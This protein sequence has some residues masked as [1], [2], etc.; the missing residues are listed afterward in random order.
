MGLV[1]VSL[2]IYNCQQLRKNLSFK[3]ILCSHNV[4][5]GPRDYLPKDN[6]QGATRILPWV[7]HVSRVK[8]ESRRIKQSIPYENVVAFNIYKLGIISRTVWNVHISTK[9]GFTV[10][11][12]CRDFKKHPTKIQKYSYMNIWS[13]IRSPKTYSTR[14]LKSIN[15]RKHNSKRLGNALQITQARHH[16]WLSTPLALLEEPRSPS[17][18]PGPLEGWGRHLNLYNCLL[19]YHW[20]LPARFRKG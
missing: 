14:V 3:S 10:N 12:T 5:S 20:S 18:P 4:T 16:H 19:Y 1:C 13:S 2:L 17:L 9:H 15:I 6:P 8:S 7:S 11:L